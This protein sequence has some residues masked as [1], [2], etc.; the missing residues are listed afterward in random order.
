MK[1]NL[2]RKPL[3]ADQMEDMVNLSKMDIE[4]IKEELA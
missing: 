1:Y 4:A 3:T 2:N